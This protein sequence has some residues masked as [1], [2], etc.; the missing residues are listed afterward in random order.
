MIN[1]N[2]TCDSLINT[3]G[4]LSLKDESQE[5][6][7]KLF[8]VNYKVFDVLIK[9]GIWEGRSL[10]LEK[11]E[12]AIVSLN[13]NLNELRAELEQEEKQFME[14]INE[15]DTHSTTREKRQLSLASQIH[16]SQGE[17]K[18]LKA[19]EEQ[20]YQEEPMEIDQQTQIIQNQPFGTLGSSKK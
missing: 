8:S 10:N 6:K 5:K 17:T 7:T 9:D 14:F 18:L 1:L 2:Q 3:L 4:L 20:S 11:M 15:L 13:Q 19:I 12:T 16:N